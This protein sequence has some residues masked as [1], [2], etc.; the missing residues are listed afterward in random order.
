MPFVSKAHYHDREDRK[1]K[2]CD[3]LAKRNIYRGRNKGFFKTCGSDICIT[4]QY[5]DK[6]VNARKRLFG[7]ERNCVKCSGKYFPTSARQ[8]WCKVC[9]P[10]K[11]FRGIMSRYSLSKREYDEMLFSSNGLCWICDIRPAKV[12]DHCHK[13]GRIRGLLCNGC[14]M[15]LPIID[16]KIKLERAIK[17]VSVC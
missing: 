11:A 2:Y 12:V 7:I 17:Y 9:V 15:L 3:N 5:R 10:T 4:E 6:S 8:K 1:C 16:D 14:N 13:T